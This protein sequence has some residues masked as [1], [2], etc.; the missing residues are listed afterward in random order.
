MREYAAYLSLIE[1]RLKECASPKDPDSLYLPIRYT[2]EGV[3]S[4]SD[5]S[6]C[7]RPATPPERQ[8]KTPS[9]RLRQ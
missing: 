4:G 9:I 2:L 6:C 8:P 7:S 3:A 5:P 1:N